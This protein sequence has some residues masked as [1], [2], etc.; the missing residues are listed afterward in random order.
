MAKPDADATNTN[1][2]EP[3]PRRP[4][5]RGILYKVLR[6]PGSEESSRSTTTSPPYARRTSRHVRTESLSRAIPAAP[7]ATIK[8]P[9]PRRS[10]RQRFR[11]QPGGAG[12]AADGSGTATPASG[13][14]RISLVNAGVVDEFGRLA[15]GARN[16]RQRPD[17]TVRSGRFRGLDACHQ[18]RVPDLPLGSSAIDCGD[19]EDPLRALSRFSGPT[20]SGRAG[21]RFA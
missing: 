4:G 17:P 2:P 6:R 16:T 5:P 7:G 10:H 14:S 1:L 8:T 19:V 20:S 21:A 3:D 9:P 13:K 18:D 12:V 15:V 11:T